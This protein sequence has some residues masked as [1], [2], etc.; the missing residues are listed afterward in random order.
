MLKRIRNKLRHIVDTKELRNKELRKLAAQYRN[1]L[2][3]KATSAELR[4]IGILDSLNINVE[5]QYIIYIESNKRIKRFYIVDFC[6]VINR[7]I[8]EIDGGYHYNV[9]Q[10][11]KDE[12]RTRNLNKLGYTVY[13]FTNEQVF[14]GVPVPFL[15]QLY[16]GKR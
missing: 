8:F 3:V 10:Q 7:I 2:I 4:F 15:K 1:E 6:D 9:S 12:I 13:R 11:E 16:Y 14:R 5:F